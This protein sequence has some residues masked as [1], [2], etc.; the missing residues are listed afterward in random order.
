MAKC[1][2]CRFLPVVLILCLAGAEFLAGRR[3]VEQDAL[4]Q[5]DER[6]Y[7]R[8]WLDE[9]VVYIV[10]REERAVFEKLTTPGEKEN[11][12]EQFWNRRNPDP[13]SPINTAKEE[14][15]RR[16][17]Y[18][19]ERFHAGIPGWRTDR[20]RIYIIHG[21]P[22]EMSTY[23]AGSN[24]RRTLREGGGS[25]RTYPME[26][27]R[28]RHIEGLGSDIVLEFVDRRLDGSYPLALDPEEKDALIYAPTLG[29]TLAE[30]LGLAERQHRP[31]FTPVDRNHYPLMNRRGD[32][33]PFRR[34]ELYARVQT[35]TENQYRDFQK[36]V[37]V[38]VQ[39]NEIPVRAH[40]DFF[41]L[42]RERLLVPVTVEVD[43]ENLT[44]N[45][46]GD[47]YVARVSIFGMVTDTS[48]RIVATF[49]DD[50]VSS[51]RAHVQDQAFSQKSLYQKVLPLESRWR[52]KLELVVK[53]QNSGKAGLLTQAIIPPAFDPEKLTLSS[54]VLSAHI[55][56][57]TSGWDDAR[58]VLGDVRVRPKTDRR[59]FWT[60]PVGV[61]V[62]LYNAALDQTRLAPSLRTV[63]RIQRNGEPVQEIVD[64]EGESVHYFSEERVVLIRQL[65]LHDLEIG[66]YTLEVE[67][68]DQV[69]G[70]RVEARE[71]FE[72]VNPPPTPPLPMN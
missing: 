26:V 67:V 32:D 21:P 53:D 66:S 44:F 47:F 17:A 63:F 55:R 15:Y 36:L 45:R 51:Y 23:S 11:F 8:K 10:T 37:Q 9:D 49:E 5:E 70:Q 29:M 43:N 2:S 24:Y 48:N 39:Y 25:T 64:T 60:H 31:F 22:D 54:V 61:Y 27:W 33:S 30:E 13:H 71:D 7:Y 3:A 20:G 34:Y 4:R 16:I 50:L 57:L 18:A 68:V 69:T 12:I 72:V 46:E 59:F 65:P 42:N 41:Q 35:P 14:H 52:Y 19:N 28:Y 62:Q 1:I 6:D 58:F 56:S 40:S 38:N